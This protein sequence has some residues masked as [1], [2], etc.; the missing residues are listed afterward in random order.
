MKRIDARLR[1]VSIWQVQFLSEC[2]RVPRC[3]MVIRT[4]GTELTAKFSLDKLHSPAD[5][6]YRQSPLDEVTEQLPF[7]FISKRGLSDIVAPGKNQ[8]LKLPSFH[9]FEN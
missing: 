1:I 8:C 9:K 7:S 5:S 2:D 4:T 6:E 3:D